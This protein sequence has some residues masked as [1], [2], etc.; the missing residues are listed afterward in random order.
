[1]YHNDR[2]EEGLYYKGNT[3]TYTKENTRT[4]SSAI[5]PPEPNIKHTYRNIRK[6]KK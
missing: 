4:P 3:Y 5:L 1:M 6:T 2:H